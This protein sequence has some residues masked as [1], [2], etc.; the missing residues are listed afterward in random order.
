MN[1]VEIEEAVSELAAAPFDP[2][3]FPFAFL[4]AFGNKAT[5]VNRL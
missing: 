4:T 3:E 1:A 2:A 5:T